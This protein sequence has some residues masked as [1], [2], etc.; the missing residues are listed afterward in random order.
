MELKNHKSK[1]H[2]KRAAR[3]ES[4]IVKWESSG[5]P[6]SKFCKENNVTI[7]GFYLWHK[8]LRAKKV[9]NKQAS[10]MPSISGARFVAVSI[11]NSKVKPSVKNNPNELTGQLPNGINLLISELESIDFGSLIKSLKE[12]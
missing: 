10:K 6:K 3:W 7:S 5:L 1:Q 11:P 12:L 2:L 4:V 9:E 8:K